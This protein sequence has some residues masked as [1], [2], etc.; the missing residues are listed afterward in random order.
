[1]TDVND[2]NFRTLD[3]AAE[4]IGISRSAV[5]RLADE[6]ELPLLGTR[7]RLLPTADVNAFAESRQ[8]MQN[9]LN[10]AAAEAQATGLFTRR[11]R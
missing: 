10:D 7:E 11:K 4:I 8:R 3:E 9:G 5:E 1:M 6:G 2:A